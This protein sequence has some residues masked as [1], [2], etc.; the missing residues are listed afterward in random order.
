[1]QWMLS[2]W[3]CPCWF[4]V[5]ICPYCVCVR[6]FVAIICPYCYSVA[7][8]CRCRVSDVCNGCSHLRP[9]HV[10][11]PVAVI[12]AIGCVT[13]T[14]GCSSLGC[15]W[16]TTGFFGGPKVT[17]E[18]NL[19]AWG[20]TLGLLLGLKVTLEN[21]DRQWPYFPVASGRQNALNAVTLST[22]M[23]LS[24]HEPPK[25]HMTQSPVAFL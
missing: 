20:N 11:F 16:D 10:A 1:M 15:L 12:I 3:S 9:A 24:L 21:K 4:V 14:A 7:I 25:G 22:V 18:S 8:I 2:P 17:F 5:V 6:V 19:G 23:P 13:C